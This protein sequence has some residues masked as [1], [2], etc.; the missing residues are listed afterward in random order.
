MSVVAA[1]WE[2]PPLRRLPIPVS[3]PRPALRV[4]RDRQDRVPATQGTLAL[5]VP[6][7]LPEEQDDD[8]SARRPTPGHALPD[9][10]RWAAQ[11][12]QA[13]I[14]VTT[15]LR[16]PSQLVRWASED[17]RRLLIRRAHLAH[18]DGRPQVA[19][20][21]VVRSTRVCVPQDGIVEASAV[22]ADGR[23]VRAVALRLEGL[24]GRWRVTALQ[25]G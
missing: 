22:V 9:P 4:V 16:P 8:F 24:D 20:R 11:F 6:L 25:L 5:V 13:A 3:Q 15:G 21:S 2:P 10:A 23:R 1:G 7:P 18:R 19:R 17:V 14:E 12:V